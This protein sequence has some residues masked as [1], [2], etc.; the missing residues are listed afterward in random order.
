VRG[1]ET[2]RSDG[3]SE[4][5][6]AIAKIVEVSASSPKSFDDAIEQGISKAAETVRGIKGAWVSEKKIKVE[7]DKIVEYRV[8]MRVSFVVE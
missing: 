2:R 7:D 1:E 3:R 6:M 4:I 8:Q 5:I